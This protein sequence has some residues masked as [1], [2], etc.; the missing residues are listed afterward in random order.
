M[1]KITVDTAGNWKLYTKTLPVNATAIGTVT[2][3][4]CETG[5]LVRLEATGAYVQVNAGVIRTLDGRK[6]AAALGMAGRPS[7]MEGGKRVNVYLDAESLA[8]AAELGNGNVS[9]GIRKALKKA[10]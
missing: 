2:R 4:D 8:I 1:S 6:V 10:E 3:D 5:A 7:E 9:D